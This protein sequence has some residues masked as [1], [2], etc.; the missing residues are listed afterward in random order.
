MARM[1]DIKTIAE[2]RGAVLTAAV[3]ALLLATPLAMGEQRNVLV[4][5]SVHEQVPWQAA[6]QQGL[7]E[8]ANAL[9]QL[10]AHDV[11]VSLFFET[12]D[13]LRLEADE[14]IETKARDISYKY[15]GRTIDQV[16]VI[17]QP[18]SYAYELIASELS[19]PVVE[20]V[21]TSWQGTLGLDSE[22]LYSRE[23]MV[24]TIWRLLPNRKHLIYLG[25]Q[26]Y[27]IADIVE[28]YLDDSIKLTSFTE[29]SSHEEW[30][31][32]LASLGDDEVVLLDS[33]LINIG[34]QRHLAGELFA[35]GLAQSPAPIMVT[36]SPMLNE[37]TLGG[38]VTVP[39]ALGRTIADVIY[40]QTPDLKSL[41]RY[42]FQASQLERFDIV[43]PELDGRVIVH[44]DTYL[45]LTRDEVTELGA[46]GLA[47]AL[48]LAGAWVMRERSRVQLL[49]ESARQ[50]RET[51]LELQQL[52]LRSELALDAALIGQL[53]ID[54]RTQTLTV[55]ERFK[56]LYGLNADAELGFAE[57]TECLHPEDVEAMLDFRARVYGPHAVTD[58]SRLETQ[59]R[60]IKKDTGETHWLKVT[61][62]RAVLNDVAYVIG[63]IYSVNEEVK[64]RIEYQEVYRNLTAACEFG[65][66]YLLETNLSAGT[67]RY[68][69][70]PTNGQTHPLAGV[71]LLQAIPAAY[72]QA[73]MS[74]HNAIGEIVEFPLRYPG[75]SETRWMRDQVVYRWTDAAGDQYAIILS[76]D[77]HEEMEQRLE[78]ERSQQL[79]SAASNAAG[80]S[81]IDHN[82]TAHSAE[83]KLSPA[84]EAKMPYIE[85]RLLAAT[86]PEYRELVEQAHKCVGELV[87][88]PLLV[89]ETGKTKWVQNQVFDRWVD[90]DGAEHQL[91]I[92]KDMTQERN[93]QV[94]LQ[95]ALAA[96]EMV[97][98]SGGIALMKHD[99]HTDLLEVN[100]VFRELFE[101]PADLYPQIS[102]D[103]FLTRVPRSTLEQTKALIMRVQESEKTSH[104]EVRFE[105]SDGS[106]LYCKL[107]L[108]T[109]FEGG[110]PFEVSGSFIDITDRR[111]LELEL[112]DMLKQREAAVQALENKQQ[113]QQQMF[114]VIGHELR[115]PAAALNMMLDAQAESGEESFAG[116]IRETASHLLNV[117]DDLRAVIEPDVLANRVASV[118]SALE[119]VERALVPLRDRLQAAGLWVK[120]Q[121][122]AACA[123]EYLFDAKGL[124]Q[125][126]INLIKNAALHSGAK[127]L[128]I[129]LSVEQPDT[130]QPM[131][132]IEFCDDGKGIPESNWSSIFEPFQRG[133][134]DEDGTGLGL[135]ICRELLRASGGDLILWRSDEG[136]CCFTATMTL[137]QVQHAKAEQSTESSASL[138]GVRVLFAEDNLTLRMLTEQILKS[139]GALPVVT[140]DGQQALDELASVDVDLLLTDIFMP[141]VD[142]YSLVSQLR[143]QGF[144]KPIIGVTAAMVGDEA[145]RLVAAGA[146]RVI[147]KP[148]TKEKLLKA[149]G[150]VLG[151]QA[152]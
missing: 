80:V 146:D 97:T 31:Q 78:I 44:G 14:S 72:H 131:L 111:K 128:M 43:L 107:Q 60:I 92:S 104:N 147:P 144:D 127:D 115:T 18:A 69:I 116:D 5:S 33:S 52:S 100:Q 82:L 50:S 108:N 74:A 59:Y 49:Q 75:W 54:T 20:Y 143:Q 120:L 19:Y 36:A 88:F 135:H 6:V 76:Q 42:E 26:P 67:S 12:V 10:A 9:E 136:G 87:E 145:E 21:D 139:V 79:I 89:A 95:E 112:R 25:N 16:V 133:D 130:P 61:A 137:Q 129:C 91:V 96:V 119:I 4:L 29:F 152:V 57:L 124:R 123:R 68:V 122:D 81:L 151:E 150:E 71:E 28:F 45:S 23:E 138:E 121:S 58:G 142:G 22:T 53:V 17:G 56:T 39:E 134:T 102:L 15:S 32:L 1:T 94:R 113:A 84:S 8:R 103:D 83:W 73:V 101:F 3:L 24:Q 62:R 140:V 11:E 141:R 35:E 90:I 40:E 34:T 114:A 55:D 13:W 63:C 106:K 85:D 70:R 98:R 65:G 48:L 66:I 99:L 27:Q 51:A 117:L 132:R 126:A 41:Q 77:I 149:W 46:L 118:G 125:V 93:K 7:L 30:A 64:A 37:H 38:L 47:L 86:T 2:W 148:V 110:I 109:R 105:R